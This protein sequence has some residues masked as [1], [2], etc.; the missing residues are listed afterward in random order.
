M[1]K[2]NLN[3]KEF[4]KVCGLLGISLPF[5]SVISSCS[6]EDDDMVTPS[7]FSGSVLIIGAG[8]AGMSAGYLL[9]QKGIDFRILEAGATHGGRIK[10]DTSF[11]DFP[12][13]LGAEWLHVETSEFGKIINDPSVNITTQTVGYQANDVVGFYNGSNYS[14]STIQQE[15]GNFKD[16]KF[17]GS[18]WLDFFNTYIVPTIQ[19][20]FSF[21]TQI[22]S[23]DYSGDKVAVSNSNGNSYQADKVILTVPL[24]ILQGSTIG[25]NP[26]LPSSKIQAI[27]SAPVWGGI[28]VFMEFSTKFWPA[29][30]TFPDSETAT[31]QRL[32]YDASFGQ[33]SSKNILGLF[34]LGKQAEQYQNL[35]G[36][37]QINYILNELDLISGNQATPNYI[38]HVVQD[39][40]KEQFIE[41]AYLADTASE[42]IPNALST[43]IDNKLYFA[44]EA[45]NDE[46]DWGGVH[47]A[48]RSAKKVVDSIAS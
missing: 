5:I 8:V 40:N 48:T 43:S 22:T 35:S 10:H 34:A 4:L 3:R 47:N 16:K 25:F 13:P 29:Y 46:G 14:T 31:G 18:S 26:A 28:K 6:E 30:V 24:K 44:G 37:A 15:F 11:T 23:I 7:D 2:G 1:K 45:Y 20:K 17:I 12:I 27:Q 19:S 32:Y 36:N 39:W 33:N 42:W 41:A 21:N 9:A 38:K